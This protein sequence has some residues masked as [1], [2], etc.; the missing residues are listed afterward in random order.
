LRQNKGVETVPIK[1]ATQEFMDAR[2]RMGVC[3]R[4]MAQLRCD[5][6]RFASAFAGRQIA[7]ITTPQLDEWICSDTS[8][9]QITRTN[10][11]QRLMTFARWCKKRGYLS[12][13][14]RVFEDMAT[15]TVP[16]APILIY[17]PEEMRKLMGAVHDW[18]GP[19]F[20][21]W[22]FAGLRSEE[23]RRLDWRDVNL[24]R[25]F[26]VIEAEKAKT[27]RRRLGPIAENLAEWLRPIARESGAGRRH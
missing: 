3:W 25:G 10:V 1:Q 2:E 22:G 15:Y 26:I 5:L 18:V 19:F 23:I 11:R 27:R 4:Y 21:I 24:D 8:R 9:A 20:A 12:R 16:P 6:G 13:E 17:T 7:E 14:C